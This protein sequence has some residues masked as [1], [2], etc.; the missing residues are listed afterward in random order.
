MPPINVV[1]IDLKDGERWK[2]S[3]SQS[4]TCSRSLIAHSCASLKLPRPEID[5][6]SGP[7]APQPPAR[8][9]ALQYRGRQVGAYAPWNGARFAV[10]TRASRFS[11]LRG[12]LTA[13]QIEPTTSPPARMATASRAISDTSP[14]WI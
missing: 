12:A 5:S 13:A 11:W 2:A 3:R 1:A 9:A 8:Q 14:G 10:S 7:A 6:R 4:R